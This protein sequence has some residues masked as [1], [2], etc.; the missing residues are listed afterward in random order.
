MAEP[1]RKETH[2]RNLGPRLVDWLP[3]DTLGPVLLEDLPEQPRQPIEAP[4]RRARRWT[5]VETAVLAGYAVVAALGIA[6]H[7]PWAD[8]AQAWL[9]AR[10]SGWW[11]MM[12]H[13]IRYEGSPGLWHSLL[14]LLVR[15]HVSFVGMHWVSGVIAA[16]GVAVLLRYAPFPLVLRILLPFG[17]WLAYQDAVVARSYVLSAALAFSAAAILRGMIRTTPSPRKLVALAIL[18]GLL[19]NL[20]VH[21]FVA[22]LGLA[23][24]ALILLRRG[25]VPLR[26]A[27]P[28]GIL[29]CFWG[30]AIATTLPPSDISFSAGTNLE[31]STEKL[32]AALGD[33][34]AKLELASTP[35]SAADV[36]PGE[37]APIPPIRFH[38]TPAEASWRKIAR[39]LAL[40]TFP[41]SNFRWLALAVCTLVIAQAV[42]GRQAHGGL[43]WIGLVPWLLMVL[44][45]TSMYF[46]PRHGGML[47]VGFVVALWLT[48]PETGASTRPQA[49]LRRITLAALIL[50]SLDQAWWTAH[51]VWADMH[52]SYSGDE[53][54]ARFLST[55]GPDK[56]IAGFYY[57]T[58]GVAAWFNHPIYCNQPR[59]YWIWSRRLHL[60]QQAPAVIATHPDILVVRE[61][62]A[63]R[64]NGNISDDWVA[65]D[66]A[67]N[68]RTA[69]G[70]DYRIIPYA[71]AHGYRE[72]HRFCGRSFMRDGYSEDLCEVALQPAPAP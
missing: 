69:P 28:V 3:A 49:W 38:R 12:L 51:A 26:R 71:E 68:K 23:V 61:V 40:F 62:D 9:L 52:A 35:S 64:R 18:L 36:R 65:P 34:Q 19:A 66:P 16:A 13:G 37:L 42:L 6:W 15:L 11:H 55:Q 24:V 32:W 30:I 7:E 54:M 4:V 2:H 56:R 44:A 60:P 50:L 25:A 5:W 48:W 21:G 58:V 1:L 43:G 17:F 47:W 46:S 29:C 57:H 39:V 53:A 70:D 59:A 22:S 10:D 41:L 27:I 72:T 45:F 67:E 20:S 63:D 8:E 33:R 31:R 14:W